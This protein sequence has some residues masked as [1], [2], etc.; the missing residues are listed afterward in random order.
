MSDMKKLTLYLGS[1]LLVSP[2]TAGDHLLPEESLFTGIYYE[3]AYSLLSSRLGRLHS[4]HAFANAVILPSFSREYAIVFEKVGD[5][6]ALVCMQTKQPMSAYQRLAELKDG[7]FRYGSPEDTEKA[8]AQLETE[9]PENYMDVEA[10]VTEIELSGDLGRELYSAWGKMLYGTRY[11][12]T[13][14]LT[15]ESYATFSPG[16]DGTTY[17]FSFFHGGTPLSGWIW[18]YNSNGRVAKLIAVVASAKDACESNEVSTNSEFAEKVRDLAA[19]LN[20]SENGNA[21][22][23]RI[24]GH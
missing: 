23:S 16:H 5:N 9:L 6:Y 18:D 13:G 3:K 17:H 2:A 20:A 4:S 10:E 12:P 22:P 8:I 11:P 1:L 24:D 19:A 14:E 15:P 7:T 21:G